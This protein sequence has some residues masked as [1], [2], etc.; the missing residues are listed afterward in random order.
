MLVS[1]A[2]EIA[3][4]LMMKIFIISMAAVLALTFSEISAAEDK[5][6]NSQQKQIGRVTDPAAGGAAASQREWKYLADLQKCELLVDSEKAKC[7]DAARQKYGQ[8]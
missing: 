7:I 6:Q 1:L 5:D 3:R 8:M 2:C 4:S